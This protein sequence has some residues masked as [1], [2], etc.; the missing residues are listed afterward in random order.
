MIRMQMWTLQGDRRTGLSK[1]TWKR[2]QEKCGEQVSAA[3]GGGRRKSQQKRELVHYAALGATRHKALMG[4]PACLNR[5]STLHSP[6]TTGHMRH[7]C[8]KHTL[9]CQLWTPRTKSFTDN[10]GPRES[11][12]RQCLFSVVDPVC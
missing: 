6:F 3:A 8:I 7:H 12:Q 11:I 9:H 2:N 4:V 5:P 1:N 10:R